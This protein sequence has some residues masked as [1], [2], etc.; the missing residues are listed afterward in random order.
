MV[1]FISPQMFVN[2]IKNSQEI[3]LLTISSA[4]ILLKKFY[5]FFPYFLTVKTNTSNEKCHDSF[6]IDMFISN[7]LTS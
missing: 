7:F 3:C 6:L 4:K 2:L 5:I 1:D